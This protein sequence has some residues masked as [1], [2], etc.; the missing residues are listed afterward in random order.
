MELKG[1]PS[2]QQTGEGTSDNVLA[3]AY[4]IH[5]NARTRATNLLIERCDSAVRHK[6]ASFLTDDGKSV[7]TDYALE[8]FKAAFTCLGTPKATL[9]HFQTPQGTIGFLS[10][11]VRELKTWQKGLSATERETLKSQLAKDEDIVT[12]MKRNQAEIFELLTRAIYHPDICQ[13]MFSDARENR[14]DTLFIHRLQIPT[15]KLQDA[16]Q[17]SAIITRAYTKKRNIPHRT[18]LLQLLPLIEKKTD[19]FVPAP[20]NYAGHLLGRRPLSD[21]FTPEEIGTFFDGDNTLNR[22]RKHFDTTLKRQLMKRPEVSEHIFNRMKECAQGKDC[23]FHCP[24]PECRYHT[25]L[26][27]LGSHIATYGVMRIAEN[28]DFENHDALVFITHE[29]EEELQL[30]LCNTRTDRRTSIYLFDI[31]KQQLTDAL[32]LITR[33]FESFY[34]QKR[35]LLVENMRRFGR[36]FGILLCR[37]YRK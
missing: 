10:K 13:D 33:Y 22:C 11:I 36:P 19:I 30:V 26:Q 3:A 2:L 5:I 35:K 31:R 21:F 14:L 29:T 25:L 24:Y 18:L 34:P 28:M 15:D 8:L 1:Y 37:V 7:S 6:M 16:I 9:Q 4:A 17:L 12:I 23:K 32:F 20:S 27:L